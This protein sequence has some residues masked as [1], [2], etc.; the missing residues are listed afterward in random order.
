MTDPHTSMSLAAILVL[1][2]VSLVSV[3]GWLVAVFR[4]GHEP[5]GRA[6][7]GSEHPPA[8]RRPAAV[9]PHGNLSAR[10][11]ADPLDGQ[12]AAGGG[13]GEPAAHGAGQAG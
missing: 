8:V 10:A 12:P 11:H 5:A 3:A 13:T 6:R 1:T 2:A 9:T 4:A 7:T